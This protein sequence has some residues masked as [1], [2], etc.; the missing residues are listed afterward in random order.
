MPNSRKSALGFFGKLTPKN[1]STTW[2]DGPKAQGGPGITN[3]RKMNL[4]L[5]KKRI[6]EISQN[7]Q[8]ALG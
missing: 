1:V 6:W 8:W 5:I 2:L 3:T 4:A 7:E